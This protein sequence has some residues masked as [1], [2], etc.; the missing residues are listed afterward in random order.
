MPYHIC[1]SAQKA[2]QTI[3]NDLFQ[4]A[5]LLGSEGIHLLSVNVQALATRLGCKRHLAG[6]GVNTFKHLELNGCSKDSVVGATGKE[7]LLLHV[8]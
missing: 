7:L 3:H 2:K 8:F 6:A 1:L 5:L 4:V